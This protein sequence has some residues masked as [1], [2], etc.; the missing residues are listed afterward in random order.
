MNSAS[1]G[2]TI[3]EVNQPP[4][5]RKFYDLITTPRIMPFTGRHGNW[6]ERNMGRPSHHKS[7]D[8]WTTSQPVRALVVGT[9]GSIEPRLHGRRA[10]KVV[11]GS[12]LKLLF[13]D[14]TYKR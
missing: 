8:G 3:D 13:R 11:E 10:S 6:L 1:G 5:C 7:R 9:T 14:K 4:S 2:D 12:I